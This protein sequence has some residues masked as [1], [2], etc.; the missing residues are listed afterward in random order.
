MLKPLINHRISRLD[1][2]AAH[3]AMAELPNLPLIM[4]IAFPVN[5]LFHILQ[6]TLLGTTTQCVHLSWYS[7][8]SI[9]KEIR[10]FV[11]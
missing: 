4:R 3:M 1:F 8:H 10:P 5:F 7:W 2:I 9:L 11:L 6:R